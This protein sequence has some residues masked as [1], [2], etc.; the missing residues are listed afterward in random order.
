MS[1][2]AK[3]E[4]T[5]PVWV[6]CRSVPDGFWEDPQNRMS[7]MQWLGKTLNYTKP[8][9][10]YKLTKRSFHENHGLLLLCNYYDGSAIQA[11]REYKPELTKYEWLFQKISPR[12]WNKKKNRH[13]YIKWLGKK[14]N[15]KTMEDWYNLTSYIMRKNHGAT[16]LKTAYNGSVLLLLRDLFPQYNWQGWKLHF[17]PPSYWK[18][19]ENRMEYMEWLFKQLGFNCASDH[20]KLRQ[21]DFLNNHGEWLIIKHYKNSLQDAISEYQFFKGIK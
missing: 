19:K 3:T 4:T 15:Y 10:W 9:D 17:T 20:H 1:I 8:D 5:D 18:V 6:V 14:Q 7:Y 16:F 2:T 11:L 13:R 12:F 21:R